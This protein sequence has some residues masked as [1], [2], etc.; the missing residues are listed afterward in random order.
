MSASISE[1]V[2]AEQCKVVLSAA[3]NHNEFADRRRVKHGKGRRNMVQLYPTTSLTNK[4]IDSEVGEVAFVHTKRKRSKDAEEFDVE[5]TTS[6]NQLAV[7]PPKALRPSADGKYDQDVLADVAQSEYRVMGIVAKN[8]ESTDKSGSRAG[9]TLQIGGTKKVINT[10]DE[11]VFAGDILLARVPTRFENVPD[12]GVHQTKLLAKLVKLD[13][14]DAFNQNLIGKYL[15]FNYKLEDRQLPIKAAASIDQTPVQKSAYDMAD[16]CNKV[17]LAAVDAYN[18]TVDNDANK[19]DVA[20]AA[21][22]LG[23]NDPSP[24]GY[25]RNRDFLQRALVDAQAY[26]AQGLENA[27]RNGINAAARLFHN[28]RNQILGTAINNAPPKGNLGVLIG[29]YS[30]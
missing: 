19:L 24:E 28:T 9:S 7:R 23:I 13:P 27:S 3:L 29:H 12:E 26:K 10:C 11:E 14:N 17:A 4:D 25:N 16:F 30:I 5:Y 15:G 6:F 18:A 2:T 8:E 22:A 21:Q 20:Q 1:N